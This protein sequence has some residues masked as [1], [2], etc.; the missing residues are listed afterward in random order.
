MFVHQMN[1]ITLEKYGNAKNCNRIQNSNNA[2]NL[3]VKTSRILVK[4]FLNCQV[5]CNCDIV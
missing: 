5:V 1:K 4:R 2:M 3:D